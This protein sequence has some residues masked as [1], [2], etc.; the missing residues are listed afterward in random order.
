VAFS[1]D[2]TV[3]ATP[4]GL[5]FL[6]SS[7]AH[8]LYAFH[9]L[10]NNHVYS[11]GAAADKVLAGT[12]G[13]LSILEGGRVTDSFTTANSS[14]THNWVSAISSFGGDWYIGLY[15]GGVMRLTSRGEWINYPE[16][17]GVEIN[18]NAMISSSARVY[19]GTL[20]RGLLVFEQSTE[21]WRFVTEGLPSKNVTALAL[22]NDVLYIGT[23]NGLA[24]TDELEL[25]G[26]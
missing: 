4:A 14:L 5:T 13:G 21:T 16:L 23:D 20:D 9:G 12:L 15:G 17:R 8:S 10:V 22:G 19:A 7:G 2:A 11:L 25:T 24:R 18:P 26:R 1:G 3:L 6:D